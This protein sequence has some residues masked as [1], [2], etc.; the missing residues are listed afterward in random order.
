MATINYWGLSGVKR[1]VTVTLTT[2]TVDTL[3]TAI[4]TDEGLS[5][6]YYAW[7]LLSDPSKNSFT[8]GD[9]STKLSAMGLIDGDTVLCTP[10]QNESKQER[11]VRKLK[12]AE[13]KRKAF[14]DATKPYYRVANT[15]DI[16][17]LP[18]T[19]NGNIPG[20]DDNANTGG[21][22]N[23]RPWSTSNPD[24]AITVIETSSSGATLILN[25]DSRN[26]NSLARGASPG[27]WY[28]LTT[29]HNNATIYGSV[30]Y[31]TVG[32]QNCAVF[33]GGNANYAQCV[34]NVYFDGNSFTIQSWVYVSAVL[35]W[36][37]IIDFGRGAGSNNI[38]LSNTYGGTGK[39][40]IY[41][42]GSQF[43]S[44]YPGSSTVLLNA[45][46]Q[47]CAT[48]TLN[49]VGNL[50][51]GLAKIY[52]DGQPYGSGV[53]GKPVNITRTLC[54]IGKSNWGNPPDPN[55]QGGIGA[56]QIYNGALTDAEML[57]NY[58]TTKSYY[59]L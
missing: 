26:T 41:I 23:G 46:H 43:Q 6:D 31:G 19:Y 20:A 2:A 17:L 51:Q 10:Q 38:L 3:I 5:A 37:R 47:I 28:D 53:T 52:I 14:G 49:T 30:A 7:S 54:Y 58:N 13:A 27:T 35:N 33:P 18:D 4:A 39:P 1:S 25:L 42:E 34:P 22:V 24:T 45:W 29:N 40:G 9:S 50:S 16:T 12:I 56:I 8:Y 36:N 11:Q 59:G 21:L 44:T 32:G 57:S 48:F 15:L 55:M